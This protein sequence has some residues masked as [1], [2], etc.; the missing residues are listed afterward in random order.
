MSDVCSEFSDT[1]LQMPMWPLSFN[2]SSYTKI[3]ETLKTLKTFKKKKRAEF[4]NNIII[5]V[6]K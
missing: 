3:I 5:L 4:F 1:V 6:I 2:R